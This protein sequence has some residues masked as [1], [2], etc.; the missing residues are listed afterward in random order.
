MD[1]EIGYCC[2]GCEPTFLETALRVLALLA[3]VVAGRRAWL[4][5]PHSGWSVSERFAA[6]ATATEV[7]WRGVAFAASALT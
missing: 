5:R 3:I 2:F 4:A 1:M 7:L 6:A